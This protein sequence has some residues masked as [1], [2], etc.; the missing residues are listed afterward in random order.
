[1][2]DWIYGTRPTGMVHRIYTITRYVYG[3]ND[4]ITTSHSSL[5]R[6]AFINFQ[7]ADLRQVVGENGIQRLISPK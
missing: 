3:P 6:D 1:M 5:P 4:D 7:P 2:G